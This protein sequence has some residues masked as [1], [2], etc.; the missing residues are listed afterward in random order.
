M[1]AV[2]VMLAACFAV[3]LAFR[4]VSFYVVISMPGQSSVYCCAVLLLMTEWSAFSLPLQSFFYRF[5]HCS[6][7][8]I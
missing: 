7:A 6:F 1:S 5:S 4:A 8:L 2:M 3:L